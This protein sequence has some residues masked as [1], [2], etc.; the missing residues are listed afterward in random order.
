MTPHVEERLRVIRQRRDWF[1]AHESGS[2]E[3]RLQ[4]ANDIAEDQLYLTDDLVPRLVA[5]IA[6]ARRRSEEKQK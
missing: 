2:C 6:V 4:I 5:E 1:H 3:I